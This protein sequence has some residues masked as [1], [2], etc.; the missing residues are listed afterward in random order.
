VIYL[1]PMFPER[2]KSAKVKKNMFLLQRLLQDEVPSATLL[3]DTLPLARR[4]VV[5][6]RSLHAGFLE[7]L[8]PSFQLSGK[9]S[10]FDIYLTQNTSLV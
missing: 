3:R 4:R 6:K 2:R 1:D 8:Q 5:V 7:E 9:S 10:R